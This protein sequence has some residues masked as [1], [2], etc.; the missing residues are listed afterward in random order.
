MGEFE[1]RQKLTEDS[2]GVQVVRGTFD[3]L[4]NEGEKFKEK[5]LPFL[6]QLQERIE[7]LYS[8]ENSFLHQ[9]SIYIIL[10]GP[11]S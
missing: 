10:L 9:Y 6:D 11:P 2:G 3:V 1:G 7:G 8:R 5:F 4:M